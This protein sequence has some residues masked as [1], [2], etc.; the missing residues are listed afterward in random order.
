[1]GRNVT[2]PAR[3]ALTLIG[4]LPRAETKT[5]GRAQPR[6]DRIR[7][8]LEAGH[9]GHR[10]VRDQAA[11]GIRVVLGQERIRAVKRANGDSFGRE[12]PAQRGAHG[13]LV[14]EEEDDRW[15]RLRAGSHC[16]SAPTGTRSRNVAPPDGAFSAQRR[17]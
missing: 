2:A 13:R 15:L 9:A 3:I 6:A 12:A 4:M 8:Q 16:N 14:V 17:P 11:R 10:D 7:L 5:I 1:M